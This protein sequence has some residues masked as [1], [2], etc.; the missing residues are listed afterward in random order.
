[1]EA[2]TFSHCDSLYYAYQLSEKYHIYV[3][4]YSCAK[5]V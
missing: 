3:I 4:Y 5:H 2:I 1:M